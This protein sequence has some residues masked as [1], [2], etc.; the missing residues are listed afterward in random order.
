MNRLNDIPV[1]VEFNDRKVANFSMANAIL[2]E[3]MAL[4]TQFID[5]G[6]PGVIDLRAQPRMSSATYQYLK[7]TLSGGEVTAVIEA[8]VKV[9][10]RETHYPGVWWLTHYNERGAIVTEIIEITTLPEILKP[11]VADMR[12]GLK[13]LQQVLAESTPP[14]EPPAH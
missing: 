9:E 12:A 7:N 14:E 11:H 13:R 10:V 5:S 6:K 4:M 1:R 3:I 8:D 2:H